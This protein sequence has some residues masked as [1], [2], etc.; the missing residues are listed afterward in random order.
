MIKKPEGYDSAEAAKIGE[1]QTIQPGWYTATIMT[2]KEG[3]TQSG[4]QFLEFYFD[5]NNGEY[6]RYYDKEYKSQRPANGEKRWRGTV[7]YFLSEKALPMLKGGITSIEESNPGFK[8]DW[9]EKSIK[10]KLVGVGIRREQYEA[11][12]G[13]L[14]FATRPYAFCPVQKVISCEMSDPKDKLL[15]NSGSQR[16]ARGYTSPNLTP[17]GYQAGATYNPYA[18]TAE[19]APKFEDIGDDEDLPF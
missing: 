14:K 9:D 4:S 12:D 18:V 3:T 16:S 11:T 5:I 2:V 7:R 19:T 15:N 8:W 10:G 6:A 1:F 17:P 13:M